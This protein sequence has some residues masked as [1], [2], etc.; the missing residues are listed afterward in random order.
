MCILDLLYLFF[1]ALLIID[2]ESNCCFFFIDFV[3][4]T[5]TTNACKIKHTNMNS[6]CE[7][8]N[9]LIEKIKNNAQTESSLIF[10]IDKPITINNNKEGTDNLIKTEKTINEVW[11]KDNFNH[12]KMNKH[13]LNLNLTATK[14]SWTNKNNKHEEIDVV[15]NDGNDEKAEYSPTPSTPDKEEILTSPSHHARR[16]MNAFLIFCK[17]HRPIVRK[18]FPHLENRGVTRIL[19]EWWASLDSD[20]ESYTKLAKEVLVLF[21]FYLTCCFVKLYHEYKTA[22]DSV[23]VVIYYLI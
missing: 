7:N 13:E 15:D 10:E 12:R 5:F 9:M 18:K 8:N 11:T 22:L 20:K 2:N 21:L 17:K 4:P 1:F 16:P 3:I 23:I 19:G 14:M 6:C